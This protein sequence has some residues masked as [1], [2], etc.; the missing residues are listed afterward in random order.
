MVGHSYGGRIV[1]LF[2]AAYPAD[3][4]GLVLEEAAH[5]DLPEAQLAALTG[6]DRETLAAMIAPL[7]G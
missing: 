5:E 7:R 6:K 3:T 1:R 4:A 2:A